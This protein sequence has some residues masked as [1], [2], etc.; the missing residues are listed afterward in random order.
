[1][2]HGQ[3]TIWHGEDKLFG[4]EYSLYFGECRV[5]V[6]FF[7]I[8]KRVAFFPKISSSIHLFEIELDHCVIILKKL[9]C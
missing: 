6:A 1:M 9:K 2:S 5:E 8:I 4:L 7:L 3:F